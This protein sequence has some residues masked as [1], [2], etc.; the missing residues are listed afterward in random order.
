M[1]QGETLS[2]DV[3]GIGEQKDIRT[4][5]FALQCRVTTEDPGNNFMPDY[6][7]ISQYRS[8][9]GI[10]IRLDAGSAFVG[11]VVTPYYDS[12]LVK[13]SARGKNFERAVTRMERALNEFRVR[14]VKTN[15]PFL[16]RLLKDTT[17]RTG[18]C[19]TRFIDN[20]PSL[21]EFKDRPSRASRILTYLGDVAVLSLI[22]I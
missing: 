22:H 10:G 21:I 14:G 3:I 7:R 11:A 5:G 6:G 8:A 17:F 4:I 1:A 2:G 9:S 16:L 19:D 15:I 20:T 12:M 13:I 18:N